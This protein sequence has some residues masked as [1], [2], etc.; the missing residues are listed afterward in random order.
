M[1]SLYHNTFYSAS[2]KDTEHIGAGLG[3]A[4]S[5]YGRPCYIA[6]DG[7]MG[8]GKTA[9][10]RG[11]A[12]VLSPGSRVKSPTYTIVNE[13]RSG[14]IPLFHFDLYRIADTDDELYGIG[15]EDYLAE[16]VCVAEWNSVLGD[17][18]PD[19]ITVFIKKLSDTER[20][21]TISIPENFPKIVMEDN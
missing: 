19:G 6:L 12:S 14:K 21:I 2:E 5:G 4:V 7:D 15:F 17:D 18:S 3:K 11:L 13:Y 9:F 10:V 1:T 20:E 16:G 8:A